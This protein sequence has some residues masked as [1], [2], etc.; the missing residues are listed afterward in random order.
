MRFTLRP[1]DLISRLGG[2]EFASLMPETKNETA[3]GI[4]YEVQEHFLDM[5]KKKAGR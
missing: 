4:I 5:V 2:A 3:T 1:T